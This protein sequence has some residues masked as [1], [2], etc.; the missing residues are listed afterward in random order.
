MSRQAARQ[1]LDLDRSVV[2]PV[3]MSRRG[4][5]QQRK[6]AGLTCRDESTAIDCRA[7]EHS[8]RMQAEKNACNSSAEDTATLDKL[9]R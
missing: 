2:I 8:S 1:D 7:V 3:E 6:L 9:P 5:H 4:A